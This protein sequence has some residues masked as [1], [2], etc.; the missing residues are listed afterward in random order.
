MQSVKGIQACFNKF[1]RK[2]VYMI[3]EM[4]IGPLYAIVMGFKALYV[5]N[6]VLILSRINTICFITRSAMTAAIQI[7]KQ[8][9]LNE[10]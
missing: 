8:F 3:A 9:C 10:K 6:Q 4:L 7:I 5:L 1:R 2:T